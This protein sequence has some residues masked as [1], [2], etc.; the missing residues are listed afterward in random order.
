MAQQIRREMDFI[1]GKS[2]VHGKVSLKSFL[3]SLIFYCAN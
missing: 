1:R 2:E 3:N